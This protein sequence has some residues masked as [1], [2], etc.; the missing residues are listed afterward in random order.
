MNWY[1]DEERT[2]LLIGVLLIVASFAAM[3][4]V[5]R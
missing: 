5:N 3:A 1:W 4:W 2:L